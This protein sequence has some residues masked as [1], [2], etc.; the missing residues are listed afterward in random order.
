MEKLCDPD[1]LAANEFFG[2]R[3]SVVA[4]SQPNDFWRR[5]SLNCYPVEVRIRSFNGEPVVLRE[6]PDQLVWRFK[7]IEI[8]YMSGASEQIL[9][10]HRKPPGEVFV[11]KELH[12]ATRLPIFAAKSKTARKSSGW[13]SG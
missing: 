4:A 6:L 12:N 9:N 5:A 2:H 7:Q 11:K 13:S 10:S 3:C 8:D 1:G